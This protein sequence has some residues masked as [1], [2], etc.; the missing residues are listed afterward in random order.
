MSEAQKRNPLRYW[1]GKKRVITEKWRQ[2][3]NRN[4]GLFKKGFIPWN[5]NKK[6]EYHLWPNGRVVSQK[7][8]DKISLANKGKTAWNKGLKNWMSEEGRKRMIESKVGK[9]MSEEQKKK[10]QK[11]VNIN[12]L[13]CEV[14]I[15]TTPFFI[16]RTKFCSPKCQYTYCKGSKHYNWN[17]D[18]RKVEGNKR[19][20]IDLDYRIWA[21]SVKKRDNWQCKINNNECSGRLE[22]HHILPWSKFPELRYNLNNGIT[23]CHFHH[24]RKRAEEIK[25]APMFQNMVS[26][27]AN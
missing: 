24:P 15:E 23:L 10:R 17:P 25:L 21:R 2:G 8:K 12:C 27:I 14:N 4:T 22:A 11:R 9:K 13:N 19:T 1:L 5:K 26:A 3:I 18:R 6:G 20:L 7:T 16:K